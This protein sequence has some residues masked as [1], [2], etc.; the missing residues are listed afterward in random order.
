M[1][2]IL[3]TGGF[4]YVG[5]RLATYLDSL[6]YNIFIGTRNLHV[7]NSNWNSNLNIKYINWK[8]EV[9]ILNSCKKMD[10]II[11]AAG[12]N[13]NDSQ[14]NP[15]EALHVNG[16]NTGKLI[17]SSIFNNVEQFIYLSTAHVYDSP[18]VGYIDEMTCLKNQHPY[19]TSHRAG[20]E[21]VQTIGKKNNVDFKILRLSNTFGYPIHKNVDAWMLIVNDVCKQLIINDGIVRLNS[22]GRQLRDFIPMANLNLIIKKMIE[23]PILFKQHSIYNIGSGES[24]SIIDITNQICKRYELIFNKKYKI[25]FETTNEQSTIPLEFNCDRIKNIVN[26]SS[27]FFDYEIDETLKFV[28]KYFA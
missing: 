5:S 3:I 24:H 23:F 10:I 14:Q 21:I 1:K 7:E 25:L 6:G 9:S 17:Q 16:I 19:A 8:D 22:N 15:I 13:A 18:L 27:N 28:N 20:E 4:G 2:N 26:Y 12:T 11:H